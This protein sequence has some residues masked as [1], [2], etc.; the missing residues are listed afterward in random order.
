[1]IEV[2]E[3]IGAGLTL[4]APGHPAFSHRRTNG[5]GDTM[6]AL[7]KAAF[8]PRLA[9]RAVAPF[10][11][12]LFVF[13]G[14][15]DHT[16]GTATLEEGWLRGDLHGHSTHSDGNDGIATVFSIADAWRDPEWVERNPGYEDDH[17][18]F[19]A[20][21]DH[22]T[23]SGCSDPDFG[24]DYV[25]PI[26][27]EEWGGPLHAN[28]WPLGD[29]ISH[30]PQGEESEVQRV[31][32]SIEEAH[33]QGA[34]FSLCHPLDDRLW[35]VPI[36]DFDAIEV[37]NAMWS[38]ARPESTVAQLEERVARWGGENPAVRAAVEHKGGG[39]NAQALRF[40][41]A[42][43][44]SGVHV[45]PVGGTDRHFV[46]SAGLPTT[47]VRAPSR[48]VEGVIEG[49]RSGET[50][51]SRSPQGPQVLLQA[52]VD[53]ESYPMGSAL[54][55]GATEVEIHWRVLRA[56]G[57]LLR[58]VE[59]LVDPDLPDPTETV[60]E[61]DTADETGSYLWQPPSSG[62]WLHAVV[63][64][65]LPEP[66]PE[67]FEPVREAMMTFPEGEAGDRAGSVSALLADLSLA[68]DLD[69]VIDPSICEPSR[70]EPWKAW[71]MPAAQESM[72]SV[73][74]TLELQ[75]YFSVEFKDR[76]PT[77]YAMG[78]ISAAFHTKPAG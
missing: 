38:L 21:T 23:V 25:I 45:P 48:D 36:E 12:L 22:R 66:V 65:P 56:E 75:P 3:L 26:C 44:S 73:Y 19:Y 58:L 28:I 31:A 54:P 27:G 71:C 33:A 49:I 39:N 15:E 47:Y 50:F 51:I 40:W 7:V 2:L 30:E 55:A 78:A 57:G 4:F 34:L 41:Q 1:M 11:L 5:G 10:A 60:I 52:V 68:L 24:H 13:V 16:P 46:F 20:I 42:W 8:D 77:G 14:C 67:E 61:I 74:I 63:V 37:W 35:S 64:D 53:G 18:H 72:G 17:L 6:N 59:G 9:A 62:G 69:A 43:L 76:E 70:W 29:F 32:D